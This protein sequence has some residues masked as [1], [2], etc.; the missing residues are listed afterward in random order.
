MKIHC[1]EETDAVYM[2][3]D[4][5]MIKSKEVKPGIVSDSSFLTFS[6]KKI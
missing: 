2:L 1:D 4:S 5:K 3:D 6:I